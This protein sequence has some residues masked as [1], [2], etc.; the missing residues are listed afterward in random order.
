MRCQGDGV[1]GEVVELWDVAVVSKPLQSEARGVACIKDGKIVLL[2]ANGSLQCMPLEASA[3]SRRDGVGDGSP[4]R[5]AAAA[6]TDDEAMLRSSKDG[7][8]LSRGCGASLYVCESPR[9]TVLR[10]RRW[11]RRG[12]ASHG[13]VEVGTNGASLSQFH[14]DSS[15]HSAESQRWQRLVPFYSPKS[16]CA[17]FF[18]HHLAVC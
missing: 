15:A 16:D 3:R 18:C 14:A 10:W 13:V 5:P 8:L 4:F 11:R 1:G 9:A 7:T 2:F 17:L 6:A 12:G